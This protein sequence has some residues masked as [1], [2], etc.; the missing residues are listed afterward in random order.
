MTDIWE[1]VKNIK[2]SITDTVAWLKSTGDDVAKR[3]T[4]IDLV[5]IHNL[6]EGIM[7]QIILYCCIILFYCCKCLQTS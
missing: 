6:H 1:S 2:Q 5:S 4:G 3:F 7:K